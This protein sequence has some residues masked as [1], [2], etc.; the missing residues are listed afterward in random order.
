MPALPSWKQAVALARDLT[1]ELR[2]LL[3]FFDSDLATSIAASLPG[4][5][6]SL[7]SPD[8]RKAWLVAVAAELARRAARSARTSLEKVL[9]A[10]R[11]CGDGAAHPCLAALAEAVNARD[12]DAYRR[13][14][15]ARERIRAEKERLA[16]YDTLVE[17]LDRTRPVWGDCWERPQATRS[18]RT[19]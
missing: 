11:K 16:R 5:R 6:T 1:N 17:K 3:R 19:G 12:I 7:S 4:E 14:W 10:I 18:G 9:D 13:A 8:E 2:G 15:D